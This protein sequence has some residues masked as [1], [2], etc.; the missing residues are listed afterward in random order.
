MR[1]SLI[2]RGARKLDV[3]I[4]RFGLRSGVGDGLTRGG[5]WGVRWES[6]GWFH[7]AKKVIDADGF[8][9]RMTIGWFEEFVKDGVVVLPKQNVEPL[10]Q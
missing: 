6:D 10:G 2:Q 8:G 1:I 4:T 9:G 3:F 5:F 7:G